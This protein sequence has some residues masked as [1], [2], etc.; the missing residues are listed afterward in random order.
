MLKLQQH[1]HIE[2]EMI[3]SPN[4]QLNDAQFGDD[5]SLRELVRRKRHIMGDQFVLLPHQTTV[6]FLLKDEG[7]DNISNVLDEVLQK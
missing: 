5:E 7:V 4:S 2:H 6:N 1:T 3:K